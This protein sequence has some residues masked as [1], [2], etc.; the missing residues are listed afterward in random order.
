MPRLRLGFAES[1]ATFRD[2]IEPGEFG[3]A[4]YAAY[5]S[6]TMKATWPARIRLIVNR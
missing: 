6:A 5:G 4:L 2:R 1:L 3:N